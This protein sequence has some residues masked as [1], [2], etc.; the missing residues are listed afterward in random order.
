ML[1]R[2]DLWEFGRTTEDKNLFVRDYSIGWRS[3]LP[4]W[5]KRNRVARA[6]GA[7]PPKSPRH[8]A[9]WTDSMT[10]LMMRHR[11]GGGVFPF[12]PAIGRR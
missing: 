2:M 1:P 3:A 4:L 12:Y 5:G 7:L 11:L 6:L 8:L 10:A 9:P